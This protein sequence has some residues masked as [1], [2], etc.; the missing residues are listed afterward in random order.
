MQLSNQK[1][2]N[3]W[4]VQDKLSSKVV[5]DFNKKVYVGV[6][7]HKWIRCWPSECS[8]INKV[9]RIRVSDGMGLNSN[10]IVLIYVI[11]HFQLSKPIENLISIPNQNTIVLYSDGTCE[12][13]EC[14]IDSRKEKKDP[15][16]L[17]NKPIVDPEKSQISDATYFKAANESILLTYFTQ[18]REKNDIRLV[19]FELNSDTLRIESSVTKLKLVRDDRDT[20]LVGCTVVDSIMCPQ[21]VTIC[22]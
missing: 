7:G 22:K 12:S 9:K 6:F 3:S 19:F 21:L 2:I 14:A 18:T 20:R 15:L 1:Q 4:A 16:L 17:Q 8:D 13:L 11:L 5:Y 10:D